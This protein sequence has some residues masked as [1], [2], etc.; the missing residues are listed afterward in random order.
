ML[1]PLHL[2]VLH[3]IPLV[4]E[5]ENQRPVLH[6]ILLSRLEKRKVGGAERSAGSNMVPEPAGVDQPFWGN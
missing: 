6:C 1:E 5:D 4:E 3:C 2:K